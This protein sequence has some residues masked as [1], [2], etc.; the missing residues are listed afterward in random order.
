MYLILNQNHVLDLSHWINGSLLYLIL[1]GLVKRN[2]KLYN[3]SWICSWTY[4]GL[5][6]FITAIVHRAIMQKC[7]DVVNRTTIR[8][9]VNIPQN[10]PRAYVPD[11]ISYLYTTTKKIEDDHLTYIHHSILMFY[12]FLS[13]KGKSWSYN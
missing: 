13:S 4:I 3:S 6:W 2:N 10:I 11:I 12:T 5:Q 7:S 8:V 1:L 9:Q